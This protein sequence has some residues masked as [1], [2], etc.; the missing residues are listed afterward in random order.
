MLFVLLKNEITILALK[1]IPERRIALL[2]TFQKPEHGLA[3]IG[4]RH[5][6]AEIHV[7]VVVV[8]QIGIQIHRFPR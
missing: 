5:L 2:H 8:R 1:E 4:Q 7:A 6:G 3:A